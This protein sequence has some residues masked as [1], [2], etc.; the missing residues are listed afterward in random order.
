MNECH[1]T[2]SNTEVKINV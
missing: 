1:S 2:V